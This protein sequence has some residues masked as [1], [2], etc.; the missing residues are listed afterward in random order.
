MSTRIAGGLICPLAAPRLMVAQARLIDS[1]ARE[2]LEPCGTCDEW[3][4]GKCPLCWLYRTIAGRRC[5]SWCAGPRDNGLLTARWNGKSYPICWDCKQIPRERRAM[6][7]P[8]FAE[9]T[10]RRASRTK[11]YEGAVNPRPL[12]EEGGDLNHVRNPSPL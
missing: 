12:M 1:R 8:Q 9:E 5:C 3:P 4:P 7:A 2:L 10:W 6:M 11:L